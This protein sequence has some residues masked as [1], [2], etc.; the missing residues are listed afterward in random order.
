MNYIDNNST[1]DLIAA[2][3][4]C[5]T[6]PSSDAVS[7]YA[8]PKPHLY[9][10]SCGGVN[11]DD[12]VVNAYLKD[13]YIE[14]KSKKM[15]FNNGYN[16]RFPITGRV[17]PISDRGIELKTCEKYEV[18]TYLDNKGCILGNAFPFYNHIEEFVCQQLKEF[19]PREGRNKR[20]IEFLGN[21]QQSTLFGQKLFPGGG[22]A[23][24]ITEGCEDCLSAYQM[25]KRQYGNSFE[26]AVVGVRS[27][28]SAEKE[29]KNSWEYINSF[30]KV[31]ICFDA[32]G[33]GRKGAEK[34]ANL[35]P[36][37]S[38]IVKLDNDKDINDYLKENRVKDFLNCWY[39]AEKLSIKGV[40][41]FSDLWEAM[42]KEDAFTTLSWPWDGLNNKTYGMR[43][44]ELSIIK[45]P[46]KVGKTALLREVAFHLHENEPD[47]NIG[48]IFLEEGIKRIGLGF[49]GL[50]MDKPIHL[51]DTDYSK[52]E[53]RKAYNYFSK[54]ERI[55]IFDPSAERTTESLFDKM[56]YFVQVCNCKVILLDHLSMF[57]Y[58]ALEN[59][60][61]RFLDK[62]IDD[63]KNFAVQHNVHISAV[64]HVNDEGKTRGSRAPV[65]LCDILLSIDRDKLNPDPI[66]KNTTTLI[67]EENRFSG[68]SGEAC[69][70]F[71]N[72]DTG[73]MTEM[74]EDMSIGKRDGSSV[75]FED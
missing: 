41:S 44:T 15:T 16:S 40:L 7:L 9:C 34:V 61:R 39:S 25:I 29:C 38:Y 2:H 70:L 11:F 13:G 4:P 3:L 14:E 47:V 1:K 23:I 67:V 46:P 45:A 21:Y 59:D 75:E 68:D 52:D 33:P 6:C 43:T 48:V 26:P 53:L 35:F 54:S 36:T 55:H 18:I 10:F 69:K 12:D 22:K 19:K 37:K 63:L 8:T 28:N 49:C 32:D 57:A 65:Q 74:D 51:P 30:D 50:K 20:H 58:A 60:E 66:I 62:F 71:Y 73:R 42:T 31:V 64:I 5:W 56:M 27:A 72:P 17:L 24:T